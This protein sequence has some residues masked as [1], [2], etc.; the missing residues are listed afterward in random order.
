MKIVMRTTKRR[1][2]KLKSMT[3]PKKRNLPKSR[4]VRN[5]KFL[6]QKKMMTTKRVNLKRRK[7]VIRNLKRVR[8]VRSLLDLLPRK[9]EGSINQMRPCLLRLRLKIRGL[10]L[11]RGSP[12][13]IYQ[14]SP[15]L[16]WTLG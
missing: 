11:K 6:S 16:I 13:S 9:L 4:R 15:S 5:R 7:L 2:R 8:R 10:L 14:T 3:L 12:Q 1:K